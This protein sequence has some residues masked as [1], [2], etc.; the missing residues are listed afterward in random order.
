M[1]QKLQLIF[2]KESNTM[3]IVRINTQDDPRRHLLHFLTTEDISVHDERNTKVLTSS[4]FTQ[5]CSSDR[6]EQY[7]VGLIAGPG[8][9]LG[10]QL[11]KPRAF[12]QL[13]LV[14]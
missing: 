12:P 5:A 11:L 10:P 3:Q 2:I 1:K 13:Y 7:V 6:N 8:E 9:G 4:R 14:E